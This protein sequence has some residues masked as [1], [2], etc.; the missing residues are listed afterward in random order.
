MIRNTR[1]ARVDVHSTAAATLFQRAE[2]LLSCQF[3]VLSLC[4]FESEEKVSQRFFPH[5]KTIQYIMNKNSIPIPI[6]FRRQ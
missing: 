4:E 1:I 5:Q 3:H 2:T 6:L